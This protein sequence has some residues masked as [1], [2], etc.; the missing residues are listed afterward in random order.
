MNANYKCA[1]KASGSGLASCVGTVAERRRRSTPR[2]VGDHT[3]TVTA[4]DKAGNVTTTVN[5]YSVRYA[6]HGFFSPISNSSDSE[7]NLV[8]AGDLIKLGFGLDGNRGSDIF[9]AG[10]PSSAPVSCPSWTPHLVA[11]GGSGHDR[12]ALASASPP[13]HYSYGWQTERLLGRHLPPVPAAAEGRDVGPLGHVHVLRLGRSLRGS[14]F[15]RSPVG[16][17]A[18]SA[19]EAKIEQTDA[20]AVVVSPGWFVVNMADCAWTRDDLGGE[21]STP[22]S[23]RASS[24]STGS[25]STCCSRARRTASTTRRACRRTSSSSRASACC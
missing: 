11:G 14:G 15:G 7:L 25:G 4:T 10:S 2:R 9:A 17:P 8:H 22:A 5:H 23:P 1:D 3:F 12:R 6:W 13:A 16:F 19:P 21:W 18:V 24:S 20:G